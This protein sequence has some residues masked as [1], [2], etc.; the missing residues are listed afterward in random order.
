MKRSKTT[1]SRAKSS[2]RTSRPR[3]GNGR[4]IPKNNRALLSSEWLK[5]FLSEMPAVEYGGV[6]LY[7]KAMEGLAHEELRPK[8]EQ[9]LM[10]TQRHV[11]LCE[12]LLIASG[13]DVTPK[14]PAPW[15]PNTKAQGLISTEVPPE[16]EDLNKVENLVLA[17]TKD[18]WN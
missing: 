14:A 18:H 11:E 5:S 1:N 15:R 2:P 10:Q 9:F 7:E 4:S 8:L 3:T 13:S 16:M 6:Q 17:E 12:E